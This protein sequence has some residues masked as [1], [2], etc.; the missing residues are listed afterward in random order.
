MIT[1]GAKC[2]EEVAHPLEL[3]ERAAGRDDEH[4]VEAK[5]ID[6]FQ[7][8][9][10]LVRRADQ[11]DR[12]ALRETSGLRRVAEIDEDVGKDGVLAAGLPIETHPGL[13]VLPAAVQAGGDP[14]G[15]F[16]GRIGDPTRVAPGAEQHRRS[17]F[18]SRPW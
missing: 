9:P 8:N 12:R 15:T 7:S 10:R 16:P 3:V 1:T 13:K 5:L 11:R 6:P 18:A 17:T 4:L 2:L 14:A